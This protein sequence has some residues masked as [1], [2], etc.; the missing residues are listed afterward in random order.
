MTVASDGYV[1]TSGALSINFA[2][3]S[4]AASKPSARGFGSSRHTG[5]LFNLTAIGAVFILFAM[6]GG[7]KAF[8]RRR[9]LAEQRY[10]GL[11]QRTCAA[12]LANGDAVAREGRQAAPVVA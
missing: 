11:F 6:G 5:A 10:K 9:E 7:R 12:A 3:E 8:G 1:L 4:S 2:A